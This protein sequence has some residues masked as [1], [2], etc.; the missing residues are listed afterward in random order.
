MTQEQLNYFAEKRRE[1]G[2]IEYPD[3]SKLIINHKY[4]NY[5][6]K[7]LSND[8]KDGINFAWYFNHMATSV[9]MALDTL[10][11]FV[12]QVSLY[13][14]QGMVEYKRLDKRSEINLLLGKSVKSAELI[15]FKNRGNYDNLSSDPM[16]IALGYMPADDEVCILELIYQ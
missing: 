15:V 2:I 3:G 10:A 11:E 1:E 6:K 5:M 9:F 16:S 13:A 8:K 7:F 4:A 14:K 12:S